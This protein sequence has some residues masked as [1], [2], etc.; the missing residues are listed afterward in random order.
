LDV[1]GT[2]TLEE[3]L[4]KSP[5]DNR[6]D[7][8]KGRDD[9][10]EQNQQERHIGRLTLALSGGAITPNIALLFGRPLE[11]VVRGLHSEPQASKL[12][13]RTSQP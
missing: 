4:M 6:Q 12:T 7:H 9:D 5:R 3:L 2:Q 10:F 1:T 13:E 11:R 8:Y